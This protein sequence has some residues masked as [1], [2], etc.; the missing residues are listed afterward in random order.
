MDAQG[1]PSAFG[2]YGKIAARLRRFNYPECVCLSRNKDVHSV[3]A[4]NLQEDS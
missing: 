1:A 2:E 4:S 3:I